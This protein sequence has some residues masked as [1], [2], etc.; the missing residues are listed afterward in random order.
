VGDSRTD[1]LV[2]AIHDQLAAM[3]ETIDSLL[4]RGPRS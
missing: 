1:D 2:P 3:T 4:H